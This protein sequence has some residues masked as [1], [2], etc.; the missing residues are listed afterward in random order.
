MGCL[1]GR[2]R[3]QILPVETGAVEMGLVGVFAWLASAGQKIHAPIL[4]VDRFDLAHDPW[5]LGDLVLGL[6]GLAVQIEMIPAVALRGKQHF[7]RRLIKTIERLAGI[8][9]GVGVFA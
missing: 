3:A 5:P 6:S 4:L 9:V 1:L 7:S 2:Q 8:D